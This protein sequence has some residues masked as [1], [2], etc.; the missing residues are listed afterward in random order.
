MA[1]E[2]IY[3]GG[4]HCGRIRFEVHGSL[5]RVFICNCSICSKKGYL[6]WLVP[7]SSLRLLTPIEDVATYCFL[8]G[9]AKHHFCRTCGT[10]PF[11]LPRGWPGFM[12][13]NV[14]CLEGIE[15]VRPQVEYFDGLHWEEAMKSF[16]ARREVAGG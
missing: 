6:H 10:S 11:H 1:I 14:R 16:S 5:E 12:D 3:Q 2:R 4:C 7:A 9:T 15:S 13:V 8:T